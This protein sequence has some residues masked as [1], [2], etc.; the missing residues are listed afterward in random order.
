MRHTKQICSQPPLVRLITV[1]DGMAC[2]CQEHVGLRNGLLEKATYH[3]SPS[4]LYVL[5]PRMQSLDHSLPRQHLRVVFA[6]FNLRGE[7]IF[8]SRLTI[9]A[10]DSWS[11]MFLSCDENPLCVQHPSEPSATPPRSW[12]Q[13][14]P[15]QAHR[16]LLFAQSSKKQSKKVVKCRDYCCEQSLTLESDVYC[17]HPQN[18]NRLTS[19]LVG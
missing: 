18:R 13:G 14:M 3:G 8:S 6:A 11:S 16:F 17:H 4:S 19:D 12:E 9:K 2:S 5:M 10:V 1:A 7:V 15:I